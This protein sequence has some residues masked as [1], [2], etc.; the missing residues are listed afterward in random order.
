MSDDD[1]TDEELLSSFLAGRQDAFDPLVRRHEDRIF[2]L[3]YRMLSDR[4]D[5]LE[6]VQETFIAA[7]RRAASFRGDSSFGTWLYSIGTNTCRDMIRKR[8]RIAVPTENLPEPAG[9]DAAVD[10]RVALR[11]DVSEALA[12]LPEDYR[13]AVALYDL[14]GVPYDEIA[15]LTG[16]PVGTV[17][18]RISRGRRLLGE[19]LEHR[20]GRRASKG[21]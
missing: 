16:G 2:G 10:E 19:A 14:G 20:S 8:K 17:K 3:A 9:T 4:G 5:A 13:E 18:S 15:R 12:K 7:F 1:L 11:L 6:A 21:R